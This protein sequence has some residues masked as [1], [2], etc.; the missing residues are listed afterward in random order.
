[1]N[2]GSTRLSR[3]S[4]DLGELDVAE[5]LR[6]RQ[7]PGR[8]GVFRP[9]AH[10]LGETLA[11][12]DLALVRFER[13]DL[14][15]DRPRDVEPDVGVARPEEKYARHPMVFQTAGE[16]LGEEEVVQRG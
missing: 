13:G 10:A 11:A 6:R 4:A 3:R 9:P 7:V 1:M 5:R 12:A 16:L 14:S 2:R 15:V 8:A